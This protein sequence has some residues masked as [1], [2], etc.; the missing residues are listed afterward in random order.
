[1][2]QFEEAAFDRF[3]ISGYYIRIGPP[4]QVFMG[5]KKADHIPRL[6]DFADPILLTAGGHIDL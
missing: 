3:I 5:L 1:M 6:D 2:L 4:M